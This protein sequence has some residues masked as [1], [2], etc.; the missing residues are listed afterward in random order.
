[1]EDAPLRTVNEWWQMLQEDFGY[2]RSELPGLSKRI[3]IPGKSEKL[4]E[5]TG[6]Y[7]S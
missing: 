1:M 4:I 6:V 3:F 2:L 5:I 7:G